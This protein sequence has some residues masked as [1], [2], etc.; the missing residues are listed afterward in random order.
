MNTAPHENGDE[1]SV[2]EAR[3]RRCLPGALPDG[4]VAEVEARVIARR[5]WLP[6]WF[7]GIAAA[8]LAAGLWLQLFG[9]KMPG[10]RG[11]MQTPREDL[12]ASTTA[13]IDSAADGLVEMTDVVGAEDAGTAPSDGGLYRIVRVMLVHRMVEKG[14]EAQIPRV[15]SEEISEQYV[16]V[17]IEI[18]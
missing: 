7:G 1:T 15:I 17:P 13:V 14:V 4:F 5:S 9:M 8:L 3:L 16:A 10:V 6:V 2:F 18:F 11:V 12:G